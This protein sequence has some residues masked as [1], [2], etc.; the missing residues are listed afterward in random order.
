MCFLNIQRER[1][2][3]EWREIT[4]S[5]LMKTPIEA[6]NPTV[7]SGR[8]T[9]FCNPAS[10]QRWGLSPNIYNKIQ[11]KRCRIWPVNSRNVN[12]IIYIFV[13]LLYLYTCFGKSPYPIFGHRPYIFSTLRAWRSRVSTRWFYTFCIFVLFSSKRAPTILSS[14]R[15][16]RTRPKHKTRR[17]SSNNA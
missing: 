3:E 17:V 4:F 16:E 9:S 11:D 12:R 5:C 2:R 7:P 10:F 8:V 14:R 6:K 13:S 1:T 15:C